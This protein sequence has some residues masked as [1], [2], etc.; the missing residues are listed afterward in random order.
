VTGDTW[1]LEWLSCV[2]LALQRLLSRRFPV[3]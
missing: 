2:V 1:D 3:T